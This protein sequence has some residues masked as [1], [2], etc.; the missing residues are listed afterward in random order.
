[1]TIAAGNVAGTPGAP[2]NSVQFNNAGVFGGSNNLLFDNANS[3][4]YANVA[5]YIGYQPTPPNEANA[6][7]LY[8][9]VAGAG[10]TGLYFTSSLD[11]DELI[12]KRKAIVYSLV[13]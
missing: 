13:L 11:N 5:Q 1:V 6:V 2:V 3:Y 10:G 12:S 8:S 7:A 4:V 9:N